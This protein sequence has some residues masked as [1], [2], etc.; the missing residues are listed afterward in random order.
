MN[1]ERF[2]AYVESD[3]RVN[4]ALLDAAMARG[5]A[6][7]KRKTV[8]PRRL[9]ALAAA[10]VFAVSV[11]FT[12]NLPAVKVAADSYFPVRNPVLAEASPILKSRIVE[13]SKT[14]E[15]FAERHLREAR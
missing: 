10:C 5:L 12:L 1:D 7:A 14:I 3:S 6:R 11:C 8:D 13:I 9:T 15:T 4:E 2:T